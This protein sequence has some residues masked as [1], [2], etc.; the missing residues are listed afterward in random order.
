MRV[1][2]SRSSSIGRLSPGRKVSFATGMTAVPGASRS[3]TSCERLASAITASARPNCW[4]VQMRGP[5]LKG[6]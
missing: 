3:R 2:A 1:P 5:V 4:P 6:M